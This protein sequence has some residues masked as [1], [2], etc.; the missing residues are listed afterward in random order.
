MLKRM[1]NWIDERTGYRRLLEIYHRRT[2]P[3]GPRWR[4]VTGSCLMGMLLVVAVTGLLLMT[5]YSPSSTNAWASVHY[6]EHMSGGSFLRGLHYWGGQA[7]LIVLGIHTVRVLLAGVYRAPRELIWA[8]GLLLFPLTL[9]WA[10]TG[11]PLAWTQRGYG[12]IQV[13]TNIIAS[14]PFIGPV[15][16][17]I[18]I[19]G[20][21]MGH[22][23]LTHLYSL[24]VA[25]F[26]LLVFGL[27]GLHVLQVVQHGTAVSSSTLHA[28]PH[29]SYWP[30]Q[31]IRNI[32]ALTLVLAV[33]STLAIFRGAP[34]DAPADPTLPSMPRPEWYFMFLFELRR[35]FSGDWEIVATLLIPL[36]VL[37][38]LLA[39]PALDRRLPR[40][41]GVAF[42]IFVV[43]GGLIGWGS[44]TYLA[45]ARDWNDPE[46]RSAQEAAHQL[47]TRVREL[48]TPG[49]I[50]PEGAIALLRD[51]PQTRGPIL[52][53]DNCA[54]CHRHGD[55][56]RIG[57]E[58]ADLAGFG[59]ESWI[60]ELLH[61]PGSPRFFGR[62]K[63]TR[64]K[65]WVEENLKDLDPEEQAEIDLAATWLAGQP[66]GVPKED[67]QSAFAKGFEAFNNWCIE[68]HKYEGDGGT[69][70]AGPDF[71][72]YGSPEWIRGMLVAPDSAERYGK[73]SNMPSFDEKLTDRDVD[74][75][76]D[77][78]VAREQKNP[79]ESS[80]TANAEQNETGTRDAA[81]IRG[82]AQFVG[83][84]P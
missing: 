46:F 20:D 81:A 39:M 26:P 58:A 22:L 13:E 73:K 44:L 49:G 10:I 18:L 8:T 2:I 29:P 48:A 59:T 23:T 84:A 9:L 6:I 61:D 19:G 62:T 17:R 64:M 66:R 47:A 34:L 83:N 41:I 1:A 82:S 60:R 67:D 14:T 68:C 51:D 78:L 63:L 24:H 4:Y 45:V 31:S 37:V 72:G 16:Q 55:E 80:K 76:I 25:V 42:R 52:F 43:G 32:A 28:Q 12:Q 36:A 71:T 38:I 57:D 27:L 11:N 65:K 21:E 77:W 7:L 56:F 15:I 35:Y 70:I 3:G 75:L 79:N 5:T 54:A 33:V 69:N 30:H 53:A 50:P 40:R 74:M